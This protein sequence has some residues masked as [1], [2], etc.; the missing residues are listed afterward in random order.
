M[1][2]NFRLKLSD[3]VSEYNKDYALANLSHRFSGYDPQ[4]TDS[5][6]GFITFAVNTDENL[7]NEIIREKLIHSSFVSSV[8]SGDTKKRVVK[9]PQL[10]EAHKSL[11]DPTSETLRR[12]ITHEHG[13]GDSSSFYESIEQPFL[14][15][16]Q[17]AENH[18]NGINS[19]EHYGDEFNHYYMMSANELYQHPKFLQFIRQWHDNQSHSETTRFYN[20]IPHKHARFYNI[21][22]PHTLLYPQTNQKRPTENQINTIHG[23]YETKDYSQHPYKNVFEIHKKN[24]DKKRDYYSQKTARDLISILEGLPDKVEDTTKEAHLRLPRESDPDVTLRH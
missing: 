19:L 12:H 3:T 14:D 11:P 22:Q 1:R 23:Y 17:E 16:I 24:F 20:E 7:T 10:R 4:F 9:V 18:R 5:G 2:K 6:S 21:W 15:Q 13:L 8:S